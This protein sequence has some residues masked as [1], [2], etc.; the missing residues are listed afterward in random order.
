M[1]VCEMMLDD[2]TLQLSIK[3]ATRQRHLQL[4][5]RISQLA[6]LRTQEQQV[7]EEDDDDEAEGEDFRENLQAR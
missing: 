5:Q 7:E 6:Q 2:Q 1:E 3:Y 4:A